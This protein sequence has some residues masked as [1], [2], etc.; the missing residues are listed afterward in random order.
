MSSENSGGTGGPRG[1]QRLEARIDK[2]LGLLEPICGQNMVLGHKVD[3]IRAAL[4]GEG[5]VT[6]RCC[7]EGENVECL[8]CDRT[9]PP[10]ATTMRRYRE[11]RD[12]ATVLQLR[13][14]RVEDLLDKLDAK[15][16]PQYYAKLKAILRGDD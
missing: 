4:T 11:E 10:L 13:I 3:A 12:K 16:Y 2:A 1:V 8:E 15:N 14:N 9:I 6:C 7:A 5:R